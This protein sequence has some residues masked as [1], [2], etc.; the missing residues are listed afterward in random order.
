MSTLMKL[1][2]FAV[3]LPLAICL[4]SIFN[5]EIFMIALLAAIITGALQIIIAL[6]LLYI[7]PKNIHLYIYFLA[8]ILFFTPYWIDLKHVF[9]EKSAFIIWGIIPVLLAI[10]LTYILYNESQKNKL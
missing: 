3:G 1:N 5:S 4:I 7:N 2:Y 8:T 6:I 9:I 10:Y